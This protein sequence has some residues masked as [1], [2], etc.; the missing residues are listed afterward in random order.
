MKTLANIGMRPLAFAAGEHVAKMGYHVQMASH[1]HARTRLYRY[2]AEGMGPRLRRIRGRARLAG[3]VPDQGAQLGLCVAV[4]FQSR[5]PRPG[6]RC[7]VLPWG[8]DYASQ[9][10]MDGVRARHEAI[11]TYQRCMA[12]FGPN[13]PWTRVEGLHTSQ[14]NTGLPRV[15]LPSY[16]AMPEYAGEQGRP[17]SEAEETNLPAKAMTKAVTPAEMQRKRMDALITRRSRRA[18]RMLQT[19]LKDT[20]IS[21]E[22]FVEVFRRALMQ[23]P[24]LVKVEAGSVLQGLH[25]R[26]HRRADAGRQGRRDRAVPQ[27]ERGRPRSAEA[28]GRRG[29]SSSPCTRACWRWPT[30]AATSPR[31]R[32]GGLR[33]R[34][35]RLRAGGRSQDHPQ[36]RPSDQPARPMR[37]RSPSW[38]H[39]A[40]ARTVN[41]GVFREVFEGEDIRQVNA[42]SKATKGP[43]ASWPKR[44]GA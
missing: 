3:P 8:E 23:N 32:P 44:D 38:R 29:P 43:G 22:Q 18:R 26:S 25:R 2:V 20:G 11:E 40:V 19:L 21:F 27:R 10:H 36:A 24:D 5:T 7:I 31:S 33:G 15:F 4:L 17:V 34:R 28:A 16:I 9:L 37:R 6:R 30:G 13:K 1:H 14:E 41:G 12:M 42:V 39:Y 35:V